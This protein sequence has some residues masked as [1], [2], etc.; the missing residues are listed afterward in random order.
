MR[1][2]LGTFVTI[3][4]E[5]AAASAQVESA[6]ES[7]FRAIARVDGLMSFHR[8]SSDIG[9]LNCARPG[10]IL[11]VHGW[12]YQVLREALRL[13][14]W[15]GGVFDCNVGAS[16]MRF[17]QLPKNT[18]GKSVRR[19]PYGEAICLRNDRSVKL[20][21][22]V[23]LDL[24]GIAKGFAV[25]Q[26]VEVLQAHGMKSGLVNAGGD[27]RT[28]GAASQ[29]V[30]LRCPD[31]PYQAQLIGTLTN[32]AIA[33]SASYFTDTNRP[34]GAASSAIVNAR[35][36][37]IV[38]ITNSVSVIARNCLL[39]DGLTKIAI[40]HG[41]LPMRLARYAQARVVTL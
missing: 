39:A 18:P 34:G 23:A 12:T 24:G 38:T 6:V 31:D 11:R 14:Q 29:P 41:R 25:D 3:R 35:R 9:R 2:L 22:R 1:P 15:S 17:G 27:L 20:N 10:S 36:E 26:A 16:L 32:G 40:L 21:A 33:T 30:W 28:F 4:A 5:G 13:W 19:F 7:A 37:R 8:R